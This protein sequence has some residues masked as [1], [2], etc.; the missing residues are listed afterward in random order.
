MKKFYQKSLTPAEM[1]AGSEAQP[2]RALEL[3]FGKKA[4]SDHPYV[5]TM[6][7]ASQFLR[8]LVPTLVGRSDA[9]KKASISWKDETH[10]ILGIEAGYFEF[11]GGAAAVEGV[12]KN[13][14]CHLNSLEDFMS[15]PLANF[16]HDKWMTTKAFMKIGETACAFKIAAIAKRHGVKIEID[17]HEFPFATELTDTVRELQLR[18]KSV[19]R[20]ASINLDAHVGTICI[21]LDNE[22]SQPAGALKFRLKDAFLMD[23]LLAN[24]A[25]VEIL[26]TPAVDLV[27]KEPGQLHSL[28]IEE[29]DGQ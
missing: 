8:L 21:N 7:I 13:F 20:V 27:S 29:V 12:M 16:S 25:G 17:G 1:N 10:L 9:E 4:S 5:M 3:I 22:H 23:Q 24:R 2:R 14:R 19:G 28:L 6:G 11:L 18:R 15:R 26:Y